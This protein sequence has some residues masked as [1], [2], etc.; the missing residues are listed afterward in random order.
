MLSCDFGYAESPADM[1][2]AIAHK[3][4]VW[5]EVEIKGKAA[6]TSVPENGVDAIAHTAKVMSSLEKFQQKL[7]AR[8]HPLLGTPKVHAST[9]EGGTDWSIVTGRRV[10]RLERRTLP[11]ESTSS[12]MAEIRE[13]LARI[14]LE[15]PDFDA[16]ARNPYDVPPLET[17]SSEPI[18]DLLRRVVSE[19]TGEQQPPIGLP[20]WTDGALLSNCATIPNASLALGTSGSLILR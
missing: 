9:I 15:N 6:H 18:V 1:K 11:G 7:S 12:V 16:V 13:I 14:K 20:Y 10:L 8:I 5:I 17:D 2:V 4:F 3:G 19:V